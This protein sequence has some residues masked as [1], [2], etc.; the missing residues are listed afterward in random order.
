MNSPSSVTELPSAAPSPPVDETKRIGTR[1]QP[2]APRGP[3]IPWLAGGERFLDAG[4]A[5]W[6]SLPV[7]DHGKPI[8]SVS[9][10]ELMQ[11]VYIKPFGRELHGKR[12]LSELMHR[13]PLVWSSKTTIEDASRLIAEKIRQPIME[14]FIVVD[15]IGNYVGV[16]K[17]LDVLCG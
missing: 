12:P 3:K 9:R 14:D 15:D 11:R 2:L 4:S 16:G 6:L 17:V 1:T 13:K 7:V 8:G 10:Y 5:P